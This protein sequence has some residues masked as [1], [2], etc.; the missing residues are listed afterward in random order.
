MIASL[1]FFRSVV[2]SLISQYQNQYPEKMKVT[3]SLIVASAALATVAESAVHNHRHAH[4]H[5]KRE[6]DVVTVQGVKVEYVFEGVPISLSEVCQGLSN[7]TFEWQSGTSDKPDC[8]APAPAAPVVPAASPSPSTSSVEAAGF[9]QQSKP[10]ATSVA[11][12]PASPS[13]NANTQSSS[14]NAAGGSIY[15]AIANTNNVDVPFPDGE[16]DCSD[17]PSQYGAVAIPW[18]N[19]GGWTSVQST[20][21]IGGIVGDIVTAVGGE[22]CTP[23]SYCSYSCAAGYMKTQFPQQ[24]SGTS[25][26][27]LYCGADNKLHITNSAY[28]TLC[29]AGAGSAKVT[30][31][32]DKSFCI[33]GTNYPGK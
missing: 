14:N 10:S 2:Q 6:V 3:N 5:K 32:L 19:L 30:S 13:P 29:T 26:G 31:S 18:Y 28:N 12:A 20:S 9:L 4:L 24:N 16:I 23:G 33:C 27:G 8:S 17:F 1:T 25:V 15:A 11:K 21:I 7:G 22:Q